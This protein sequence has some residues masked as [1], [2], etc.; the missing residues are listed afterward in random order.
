MSTKQTAIRKSFNVPASDFVTV[1]R[2]ID[3]G[4]PLRT[5]IG[6]KPIRRYAF[7]SGAKG[8]VQSRPIATHKWAT[9][10]GMYN[11]DPIWAEIVQNV[12]NNRKRLREESK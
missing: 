11:N 1:G 7:T 6:A 8:T 5:L 12:R 3:W 9:R 10:V 2:G 4:W